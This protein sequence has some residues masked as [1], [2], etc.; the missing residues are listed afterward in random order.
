[1]RFLH[2]NESFYTES[3][4]IQYRMRLYNTHTH[5][6]A[7]GCRFK[8]QI[9]WVGYPT[10]V[11]GGIAPGEHWVIPSACLDAIEKNHPLSHA[12]M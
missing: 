7:C 8:G 9:S 6:R 12:A 11:S 10:P 5:A 2:G 3:H 1:M 4:A